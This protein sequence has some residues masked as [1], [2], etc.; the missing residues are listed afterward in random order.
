MEKG[1][2]FRF[3]FLATLIGLLCLMMSG[4]CQPSMNSTNSSSPRRDINA[5][6]R[7]HDQELMAIPGVVGVYV[8]LAGDGQTECLK[9]MAARKTPQLERQVPKSLEGYRVLVEETGVI[10]PLRQP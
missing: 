8:G 1:Y 9:V 2:H 7:D 3:G 4:A 5:V 10:R 6:L